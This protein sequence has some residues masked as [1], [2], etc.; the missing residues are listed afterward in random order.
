MINIKSA[1]KIS[2]NQLR[3][4]PPEH[5]SDYLRNISNLIKRHNPLNKIARTNGFC[6]RR[7]V[8]KRNTGKKRIANRT[9]ATAN[10]AMIE[11]LIINF[12]FPTGDIQVVHELSVQWL[13]HHYLYHH[14]MMEA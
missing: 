1:A 8:W 7:W 13:T 4:K 12:Y 6:N 11:I 5:N 3:N 14:M 10:K 2:L 9:R